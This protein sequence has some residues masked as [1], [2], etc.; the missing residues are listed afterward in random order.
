[1]RLFVAVDVP[2]DVKDAIERDVVGA[3]RDALP[4]A[5]WTRPEGRHLTLTFL[6]EVADERAT[7]VGQALAEAAS[8]HVGFDAAFAELGG[9]P[10]VRRPRV[11]WLGVDMGAE[12]LS[13]LAAD[14]EDVLRPLGFPGEDRPFRAHVT[15]ARFPK[16][17]LVGSMPA[18]AVPST[19]FR[20]DEVVLF[21]SQ[22][23]PKGARY[24]VLERIPL[25]R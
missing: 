11:L 15:L 9:F 24:A 4:G 7:G 13:A 19:T 18:V 2:Q 6:G 5:R 17:R 1:M 25:A 21:R 10:N 14:V 20:V 12:E 16:P 23:H 22:L 3:L 8:R